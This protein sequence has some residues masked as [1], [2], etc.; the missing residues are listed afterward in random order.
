MSLKA[1]GKAI[2]RRVTPSIFQ[3][4]VGVCG[5]IWASQA[6]GSLCL[7][8][9]DRDETVGGGFPKLVCTGELSVLTFVTTQRFS[10]W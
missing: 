3:D 10:D 2:A 6:S 4:Q 1:K 5:F 8:P 7:S 9:E